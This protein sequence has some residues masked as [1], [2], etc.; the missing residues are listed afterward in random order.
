MA[1]S[2]SVSRDG[3]GNPPA[4][5]KVVS[6]QQAV[7]SKVPAEALSGATGEDALTG[8][9]GRTVVVNRP[10]PGQTVVI[11]TA[12]ATT[13][14]LNFRPEEADVSADDGDLVM[15]FPDGPNGGETRL[16]FEELA[17][18]AEGSEPVLL[19]IGDVVLDAGNVYATTLALADPTPDL[20]TVTAAGPAASGGG[21]VYSDDVGT[22]IG[23]LTGSGVLGATDLTPGTPVIPEDEVL[24][25]VALQ[26]FGGTLPGEPPT[27][28]INEV[29]L[30]VAGSGP[31]NSALVAQLNDF[32]ELHNATGE[33]TVTA[34]TTVEFLN[35]GGAVV[36]L[37]LPDGVTIPAG[38]FLVL[39]QDSTAGEGG[40]A[41][42]T[43]QVF[44]TAGNLVS[45]FT[46]A[47]AE[48]WLLGDDT[49][50][51]LGVNLVFD[52]TD[53]LDSFA[54]NLGTADLATLTDAGWTANGTTVPAS[55]ALSLE[56]FNG[57]FTT[58]HNIFSRVT[59]TDS[60][61][62]VDWTTND[63]ATEGALNDVY[64]SDPNPADP[65]HDDL[66]PQQPDG[67]P[68][69]G[70]T[71]LAA[72]SAGGAALEG[73]AGP[74]F[75]FGGDGNDSLYGGTQAD[76]VAQQAN[77]ASTDP[78][79]YHDHNDFLFGG[80][81]DDHLY[82]G[83]GGDYI[84]GGLGH[85]GIDGG[86][87][88]DTIFGTE[89]PIGGVPEGDLPESG[90]ARE[91]EVDWI[92]G[93]GLNNQGTGAALIR[94][95]GDDSID[96]GL[97]DD[98]IA[99]EALAYGDGDVFAEVIAGD[100]ADPAM[101]TGG[102]TITG[103]DGYDSIAGEALA[104][105]EVAE[106]RSTLTAS[107]GGAVGEDL[108]RGLGAKDAIAG[109]VFAVST[110]GTA[111]ASADNTATNGAAGGDSITGDSGFNRLSGDV[112]AEAA[113]AATAESS[114]QATGAAASAG[115]DTLTATEGG[116]FIAGDA[117]AMSAAATAVVENDASGGGSAG[118]DQ[119]DGAEGLNHLA[120]DV[121]VIGSGDSLAEAGNSGSGEARAGSDTVFGGED[122]DFIAGDALAYGGGTA[123]AV[124]L[125][126]TLLAV[127]G[128]DIIDSGDGNDVVAGDAL[129]LG[130]GDAEV[131]NSFG[132]AMAGDDSILGGGGND[133]IAGDALSQGG[134]A[135]VLY[136]GDDTIDGGDGADLL[137]GDA[138]ATDG[139]TASSTLAGSDVIYGGAGADTIHGDSYDAS[140]G[141]DSSGADDS[142]Y[143]DGGADLILGGGGSDLLVG[144]GED[145]TLDGGL[146]NDTLV[147]GG[148]GDSFII[149]PG[150]TGE[151]DT[152]TD[153]STGEGDVIDLGDLLVGASDT[154]TSLDDYL[155]VTFDGTDSTIAVDADGDGSGYTDHFVVVEGQDI[156]APGG[157]QA[158]ILQALIDGGNLTGESS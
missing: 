68:L 151:T 21:A 43:G 15:L 24:P 115:N 135:S 9:A 52:D 67:D 69:A 103:Y 70:Q 18:V 150:T 131:E 86:S 102:D 25:A 129:A 87:G 138:L 35:P 1:E 141:S 101:P 108:L 5:K 113:V 8:Q 80:A 125:S 90:P 147:G 117:F 106:A 128:S 51:P 104:V 158:D 133:I 75:L 45:D 4:P 76:T 84:I 94:R 42:V 39:S 59:L 143:G 34:A 63:R 30:S 47:G 154:G 79:V 120:G 31:V 152:L 100:S 32:V 13:Y 83:A 155:E 124:N 54:A 88:N 12:P 48:P 149:G 49:S 46:I 98:L 140:G 92:A 44:D 137:A 130:G 14:V 146:G 7:S 53:S 119:I 96:G 61:S 153:F 139:G 6:D 56:T 89:A 38:G 136:G 64:G 148:G 37:A 110:S 116:D 112:M 65:Q 27:L 156:T 19:Q 66:D 78:A 74:D 20:E 26:S 142:L 93:D 3:E 73:G 77:A 28:L 50:A 144:G 105:G 109:E 36:P 97:G 114:N 57:V 118:N 145:D 23:L 91:T 122:I 123:R 81:G 33:D 82:G 2:G 134:T 72:L 58:E 60:D 11:E 40:D 22:P 16:V 55:L 41:T 127:V 10:E 29:G 107:A 62:E 99:G 121:L 126:P 17:A 95:G 157:S 71:I 132:D 111:T 85:D